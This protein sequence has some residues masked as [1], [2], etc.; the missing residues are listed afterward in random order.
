[1]QDT[2]TSGMK[3][4]AQAVL[5]KNEIDELR[6]AL[7]MEYGNIWTYLKWRKEGSAEKVAIAANVT[8]C[9][10]VNMYMKQHHWDA[11]PFE[12]YKHMPLDLLWNAKT[13]ESPSEIGEAEEVCSLTCPSCQQKSQ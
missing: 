2:T 4:E 1:M 6:F 8:R 11:T 7:C 9:A 13:V 12:D 10:Q 5:S 3:H